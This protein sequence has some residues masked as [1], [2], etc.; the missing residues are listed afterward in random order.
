MTREQF[1]SNGHVASTAGDLESCLKM[2][3][4]IRI[5][6]QVLVLYFWHRKEL[7]ERLQS[8]DPIRIR[9]IDMMA[10]EI[11]EN[12]DKHFKVVIRK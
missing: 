6:W 2:V 5:D 11:R 7:R 4:N 8:A 12:F 10:Q 9:D 3:Y 1:L